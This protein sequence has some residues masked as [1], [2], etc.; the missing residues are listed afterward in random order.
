MMDEARN[1]ASESGPE[2]SR[3]SGRGGS[4][5]STRSSEHSI[6]KLMET[7]EAVTP[8]MASKEAT[9]AAGMAQS[10]PASVL[11][12]QL[13]KNPV[14]TLNKTCNNLQNQVSVYF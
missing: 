7:L 12:G 2:N 11:A 4:K 1:P 3:Q 9:E 5:I 6:A 13:E 14:D 8:K 10:M